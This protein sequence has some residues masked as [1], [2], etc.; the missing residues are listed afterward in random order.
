MPRSLAGVDPGAG[1]LRETPDGKRKVIDRIDASG[2]GDVDMSKVV[3]PDEDGRIKGE[4]GAQSHDHIF[5]CGHILKVERILRQV[6][7]QSQKRGRGE[8]SAKPAPSPRHE[9]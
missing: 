9:I 8:N 5:L 2:A 4:E 3:E 7:E 6:E 1:G